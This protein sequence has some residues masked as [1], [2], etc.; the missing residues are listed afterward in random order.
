MALFGA[1]T[2]TFAAAAGQVADSCGASADAEMLARAR[3]SV[4]AAIGHFNA[5]QDWDWLKEEGVAEK[6]VAPFSASMTWGTTLASAAGSTTPFVV[7]DLVSGTGLLPGTRVSAISVGVGIGLTVIPSAAGT[8]IGV[9]RDSYALPTLYKNAYSVRLLSANRALR[10]VDQRYYDQ[11]YGNGTATGTPVMYTTFGTETEGQLR[12][13]PAPGAA[14]ALVVRYY[15]TMDPTSATLD[16]PADFEP[17]LMAWAKWHFLTDKG[18]DRKNQ[19]TTWFSLAEEGLKSMAQVGSPDPSAN[20][21][22]IS[23]TAFTV[24]QDIAESCGVSAANAEMLHRARRS[25]NAATEHF[26]SRYKWNFLITEADP[27]RVVAPF[28]VAGVTASVGVASAAAPAGHGMIDGDILTG[29][30]FAAGCRVTASAAGGVG[31]SLPVLVSGSCKATAIR[32]MYD[33][34]DDWKSP[35]SV[36]L[37]SSNSVLKYVNRRFYDRE[38]EGE[39][40]PGTVQA[41]ELTQVSAKGKIRLLPPPAGGDVL[42]LRYYRGMATGTA[43]AAPVTLD[44]PTDYQ[45]YLIAWAKWHFLTDVGTRESQAASWLRLGEEG[46]K[47]MLKDQT[48]VPDEDLK[49]TPGQFSYGGANDNSTRNINWDY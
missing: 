15:R 32:D 25:L 19:A 26:N 13:F 29:S 48:N 39:F 31:I 7:N 9:I 17:Y 1:S 21:G 30:I 34:P 41:Y 35:Y 43:T 16:I 38:T 27:V 44:M 33:V 12:I 28:G 20:L 37:L 42:Q 22:Y 3:I 18:E 46:L 40:S 14:D 36:R 23:A 45:P 2:T 4:S 5:K 8:T 6:V 24:V 47:T 10:P 11:T 49:M